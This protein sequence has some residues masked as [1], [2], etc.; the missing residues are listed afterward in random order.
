[1]I[2]SPYATTIHA[3][4]NYKGDLIEASASGVAST[5]ATEMSGAFSSQ[6]AIAVS[7]CVRN[8]IAFDVLAC[9]TL[10]VFFCRIIVGW[11]IADTLSGV[12]RTTIHSRVNRGVLIVAISSL[13]LIHI[14]RAS[15]YTIIIMRFVGISIS[16]AIVVS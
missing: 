16:I 4:N 7:A 1:L 6:G 11:F 8:L 2:I 10:S 3:W 15:F 14:V 9:G 12:R 5:N 13:Y